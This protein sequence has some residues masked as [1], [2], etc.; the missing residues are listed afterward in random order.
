[1]RTGWLF[2]LIGF[3]VFWGGTYSAFKDLKQWLDPGQVVTLRYG[4]AAILLLLCWPLMRGKSPRGTDLI[5]TFVMGLLVFVCAPRLQVIATQAGQAGD[6]SV[7]V[8]LEPLVVTVGAALILRER[9]PA[10][11]WAGFLFGML[12]VVLLAN[13]WQPGF[14][15]AGL[16]VNLIFIASFFCESA[17]SVM[18]KPLIERYD[19]LK[20]TTISLITGVAVNFALDGPSTVAAARLMPLRGWLE[21]AAMRVLPVNAVAMTVFTQPFSGTVIAILLLGEQP[22]WGQLWGGLAIASGLVLGLRQFNGQTPK[23]STASKRT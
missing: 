1:M 8:A 23:V 20:V 18:G 11:R 9:V 22:H 19:F 13:V 6:M 14:R 4:V 2:I 21:I 3:N 5:K 17:Y 16:G 15:L 12:G 7:L 10:N